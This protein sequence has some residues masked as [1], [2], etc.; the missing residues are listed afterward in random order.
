MLQIYRKSDLKIVKELACRADVILENFKVGN[1]AKYNLDYEKV[2]QHNPK[3]IYCSITGF[4]QTGPYATRP[5]YDFIIQAM[6]GIMDLTGES[7]GEPQKPG[8]AYADIFTGVYS[9]IA[10]QSAIIARCKSNHGTHIDMS[11]FDTQ[12]GV[13]ANQGATYFETG[14]TPKRMG[15]SHPVI[16][17]YQKFNT[18]D[19]AIIIACGNDRQFKS[20]CK[21]LGWSFYKQRAYSTNENRVFNRE[22]LIRLIEKNLIRHSKENW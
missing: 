17:P 21:A 6:G 20:L 10:I 9:V 5:G 13:L 4:G 8:V 11:L 16:V 18:C 15:N 3:I 12:L 7:S 2:K 19:G 1:L 22:K 14:I